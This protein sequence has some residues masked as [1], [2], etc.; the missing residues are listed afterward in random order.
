M[1]HQI[2]KSIKF[3][4]SIFYYNLEKIIAPTLPLKIKWPVL[5]R[6]V[7][8]LFS[9]TGLNIDIAYLLNRFIYT[10]LNYRNYV[11]III[12]RL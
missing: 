2:I 9:E 3:F 7:I 10:D 8:L 12:L 4:Y 1:H 11:Y 6:G 5:K